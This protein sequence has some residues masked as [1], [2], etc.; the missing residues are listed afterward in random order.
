MSTTLEQAREA[1]E[2]V[3]EAVSHFTEVSGIGITR[4]DGGGH[5]VKVLL[6][7]QPHDLS[8]LPTMVGGVHVR[9]EVVGDITPFAET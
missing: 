1:K 7:E 9:Y 8:A 6:A 2:A 3:R 5:E 4:W